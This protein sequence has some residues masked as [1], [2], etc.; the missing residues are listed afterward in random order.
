MGTLV[1]ISIERVRSPKKAPEPWSNKEKTNDPRQSLYWKTSVLLQS[2]FRGKE[3]I[4]GRDQLLC[5]WELDW[6]LHIF[7]PQHQDLAKISFE[8]WVS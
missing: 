4:I 1:Y 5:V 8:I 3:D 2:S 6:K 7:H